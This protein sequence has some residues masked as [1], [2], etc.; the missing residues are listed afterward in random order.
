M[1]FAELKIGDK[2]TIGTDLFIKTDDSKYPTTIPLSRRKHNA[3]NLSNGHR[4]VTG[5]FVEVE[6][7]V[8]SNG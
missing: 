7:A 1:K 5:I 6:K 2:F 3:I 8:A 4:I